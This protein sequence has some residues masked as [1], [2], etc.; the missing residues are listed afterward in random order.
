[1]KGLIQSAAL[2]V[3][4]F[5]VFHPSAAT[6]NQDLA[7]T[8]WQLVAFGVP[9]AET[10]LLEGS[11]ITLRLGGDARI[12]GSGGCNTYGGSY[13]VQGGRISFTQLI[14]TLRACA[15]EAFTRQEKRYFE[16]L[17]SAASYELAG[18]QLRIVYTEAGGG[19]LEFV[20]K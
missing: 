2:V 14:S 16:A 3:V 15:D 6:I 18:D 4:L 17:G 11:T 12:T 19:V 10:P 5:S 20:K 8:E 9:N 7:N 1:M 13:D